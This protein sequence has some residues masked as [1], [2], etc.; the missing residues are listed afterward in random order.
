M[1]RRG[2]EALNRAAF[3]EQLMNRYGGRICCSCGR[4]T[5]AIEWHHIVPKKVGGSDRVTNFAPLCHEC[6]AAVTFMRPP[7][8]YVRNVRGGRPVN[9][10]NNYR[11]IIDDYIFC[12][13]TF[14]ACAERLGRCHSF[15]TAKWFKEYLRERGIK[16]YKNNIAI[17]LSKRGRIAKG[18]VIGK[19]KYVN[20]NTISIKAT[21]E[22]E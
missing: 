19:I 12:R 3:R 2:N 16:D 1:S 15:T 6:H 21:E 13:I 7:S 18:D 20:G 4:E 8:K 5:D 9:L 10:P 11:E 14:N 22:T 17:I